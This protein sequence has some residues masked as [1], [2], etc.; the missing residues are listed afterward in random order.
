MD[1]INELRNLGFM[2]FFVTFT[3]Q[4]WLYRKLNFL[5]IIFVGFFIIGQYYYSLVYMKFKDDPDFVERLAWWNIYEG[6]KHPNWQPGDSVY[7]RH[8][9]Y[10]RDWFVLILMSALRFINIFFTADKDQTNLLQQESYEAIR[11]RY[12][13]KIF[14]MQRAKNVVS[15]SFTMIVTIGMIYFVGKGETNIINWV[16]FVLVQICIV[17][18]IKNDNKP[19]TIE[20]NYLISSIIKY[21]SAAIILLDITFICFVGE[22]EKPDRP[23]SLDQIF[24]R[25]YPLLYSQLDIIG[26][27]VYSPGGELTGDER[28]YQL[29]F[30]FV[31]HIAFFIISIYLTYQ[32]RQKRYEMKDS[33]DFDENEYK[34][35]FTFEYDKVTDDGAY[36]KRN[37]IIDTFRTENTDGVSSRFADSDHYQR[38]SESRA[39]ESQRS[40][41]LRK[42]VTQRFVKKDK[43]SRFDFI[44]HYEHIRYSAPF[45]VYRWSDYWAVFDFIAQYGHIVNNLIIVVVALYVRVSLYMW[46]NVICLCIF[47]SFAV[48]RLDK[49]AQAEF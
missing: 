46:L 17:Y 19:S 3:A 8:T 25:N 5:L 6:D 32:A 18:L 22:V 35:L 21:Y 14:R 44:D 9:P 23:N 41:G 4:E 13:D 26:V 12:Q 2:V 37:D 7:F 45:L 20:K 49:K 31:S 43:Y 33:R 47:Y 48:N 16:Y 34:K 24:K 27:R 29:K 38:V 42:H 36:P 1:H 40:Q 28:N 10:V 30:R 39:S 11:D 15:S